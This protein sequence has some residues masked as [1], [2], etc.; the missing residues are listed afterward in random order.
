MWSFSTGAAS[1]FWSLG[2]PHEALDSFDR[3]LAADPDHRDALGNRGNALLKLNRVAEALAAYDRVLRL[4]P[5]NAP[6]LT[7]RAVALRRLDRPQ[8]AAMSARRALRSRPD[9]RPGAFR[10]ERRAVDAGRFQRRL[11]RL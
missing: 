7:N 2:R 8:E 4:A 9:H 1:R 11:A 6:L 10:R 5:G 3:V